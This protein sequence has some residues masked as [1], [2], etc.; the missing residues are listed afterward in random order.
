MIPDTVDVLV[1]VAVMIHT[2]IIMNKYFEYVLSIFFSPVRFRAFASSLSFKAF[3]SSVTIDIT[4]NK[5][6]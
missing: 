4:V 2:Y 1:K 3:D 5:Y 6:D